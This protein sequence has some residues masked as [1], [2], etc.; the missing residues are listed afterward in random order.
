MQHPFLAQY[1]LRRAV[2]NDRTLLQYDQ[3]IGGLDES[4]NN[5]LD[6]DNRNAITVARFADMPDKSLNL[7]E[8]E[9]RR[10]LVDQKEPGAASQCARKFN[11]FA[12]LQGQPIGAFGELLFKTGESCKVD[13]L[14]HRRG[15]AQATLG[16]KH[17]RHRNVFLHGQIAEWPRNLIRTTDAEPRNSVAT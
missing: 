1:R 10:D 3:A 13:G 16:A 6:P 2:G 15:A 14:G 12:L 8:G 11:G 17:E 9:P 4:R 7:G 5:V